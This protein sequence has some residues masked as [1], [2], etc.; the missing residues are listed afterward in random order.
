MVFG[1]FTGKRSRDIINGL[2]GIFQTQIRQSERHF[3]TDAVL[4]MEDGY[5]GEVEKIPRP[6]IPDTEND[7]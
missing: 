5:F 7:G 2:I 6:A 3:L 4:K 1:Q